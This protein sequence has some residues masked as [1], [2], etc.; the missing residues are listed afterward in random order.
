MAATSFLFGPFELRDEPPGL[1]KE[2]AQQ[3]ISGRAL[4]VLTVLVRHAGELIPQSELMRWV[5]PDGDVEE[6]NLRVHVSTL[7]KVLGHQEDHPFI[8]NQAGSGYRF[9]HAVER[10]ATDAGHVSATGA[11]VRARGNLP[12]RPNRLIGRDSVLEELAEQLGSRRALTI[13]G[14]GGSG[15]TSV[16]VA[17][18]SRMAPE[19]ADG[20][21]FVDLSALVDG[22]LVPSSIASVLRL[23]VVSDRQTTELAHA[24]QRRRMLLLL[25]NCEHVAGAVALLV[26]ALIGTCPHLRVLA[27][28]RQPLGF[29]REEVSELKPLAVPAASAKTSAADAMSSPAAQLFVERLG[30]S[31]ELL[32][33]DDDGLARVVEICRSLDGLPLAIELAAA[34]ARTLGL[35]S[36]VHG[37]RD[38][39]LPMALGPRTVERH[40]SLRSLLDWGWDLLG[41]P[42]RRLLARVAVFR[43]AFDVRGAA[44]LAEASGSSVE[45]VV[46]L[47]RECV[48][49]H[50]IVEDLSADGDGRYRLLETTR[51]HALGRL[52]ASGAASEARLSHARYLHA[53][54]TSV[55]G[56]A[57]SAKERRSAWEEGVQRIDDVRAALDWTFGPGRATALG[58]DLLIASAGLWLGTAKLSEFARRIGV[59]LERLLHDGLQ[60]DTREMQLQMLRGALAFNVVGVDDARNRALNRALEI[61]RKVGARGVQITALWNR[62]GSEHIDGNYP[63]MHAWIDQIADI[64]DADD[65]VESAMVLRLRALA[66]SRM[67]RLNQSLILGSAAI[68]Q[69]QLQFGTQRARLRYDPQATA[70]ANQ[71]FTS[72]HRGRLDNALDTL[73]QAVDAARQLRDPPTLC[74]VLGQVAIAVW[75][76]SGDDAQARHGIAELIEQAEEHGFPFYAS[77]ARAY[78]LA[79]DFRRG[80]PNPGLARAREA[81]AIQPQFHKEILVTIAAELIDD[82]TLVRARQGASGWSTPAILRAAAIRRI[83]EGGSRAP[84]AALADLAQAWNVAA[85]QGGVTWQILVLASMTEIDPGAMIAG[86]RAHD[87]LV[88]AVLAA[89]V[90][91]R[92]QGIAEALR[93]CGFRATRS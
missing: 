82:A 45:D 30:E 86:M 2:G 67:G 16:A 60:A 15:K 44:A 5:W 37:L 65:A 31:S 46:P 34:Y 49:K 20:A 53:E 55:E 70:L 56:S 78:E 74:Y 7:R 71:A 38:R 84:E 8:V 50:L 92:H 32:E 40:R 24:L 85:A 11:T 35:D 52:D 13:V 93:A 21:W 9:V 48:Q 79:L 89:P 14:P 42:A 73:S 80:A 12:L 88:D 19:Q 23:P 81:C 3:R 29:E 91:E 41:T 47:L 90:G 22:S 68:S 39:L 4:Q 63:A 1:Y 26:E 36:L 17:L 61:A 87:R 25:D 66:D 58:A 77:F 76:W 62:M 10:R 28:S 6:G 69:A 64:A 83:S 33:L 59:A 43:S 72:W 57:Q 51:A 18:A 54:L 27:T 75:A